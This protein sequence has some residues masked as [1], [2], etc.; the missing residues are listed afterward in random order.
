MAVA[1]QARRIASPALRTLVRRRMAEH[2]IPR[3]DAG[4]VS[5][6]A[7]QMQ[8]LQRPM[9]FNGADWGMGSLELPERTTMSAI[10]STT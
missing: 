4:T 8:W 7:S 3:L 9:M 6:W 5:I 2:G 1:I 10:S